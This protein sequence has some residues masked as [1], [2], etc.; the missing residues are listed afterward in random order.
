MFFYATAASHI[1]AMIWGVEH[2][3][4]PEYVI[5]DYLLQVCPADTSVDI[6]TSDTSEKKMTIY[7]DGHV[8]EI[9]D[10]LAINVVK[11]RKEVEQVLRQVI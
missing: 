6:K 10:T 5:R 4:L 3:Q 2:A 11:L 1:V 8:I 7:I 9:E